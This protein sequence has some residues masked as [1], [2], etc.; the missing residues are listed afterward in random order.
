MRIAAMP[1]LAILWVV[2]EQETGYGRKDNSWN[3][4]NITERAGF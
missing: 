4:G 3:E 1:W 2:S